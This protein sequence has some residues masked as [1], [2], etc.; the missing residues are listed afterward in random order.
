[1]F[2]IPQAYWKH[3][4]GLRYARHEQVPKE[5]YK[6]VVKKRFR[7]KPMYTQDYMDLRLLELFDDGRRRD[8]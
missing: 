3:P 1:M 2:G 4:R 8:S 6:A 5:G 7:K